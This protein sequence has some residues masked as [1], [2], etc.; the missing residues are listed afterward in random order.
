[1]YILVYWITSHVFSRNLPINDERQLIQLSIN[2][3]ITAHARSL[4]HGDNALTET[5][6][7][8]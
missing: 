2:L 4:F 1:M 7:T 5:R 3:V 6:S 8:F